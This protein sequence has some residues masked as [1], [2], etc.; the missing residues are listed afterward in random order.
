MIEVTPKLAISED[1]LT[2]SAIRA[3]G[4][5][6]QHVNKASTAVQLRFDIQGSPSLSASEKATLMSFPD[7]RI[8]KE[9]FVVIRSEESRSQAR[10]REIALRR[11]IELLQTA[12]TPRK[13]RRKTRPSKASVQQRLQDKRQKS[14]IKQTRRKPLQSRD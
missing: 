14:Q 1:E 6:G 10:N 9:G 12:F 4:P 2:W 5:G 11:L 13:P 7:Q 3:S 8:S